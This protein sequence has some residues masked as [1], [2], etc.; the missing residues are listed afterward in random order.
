MSGNPL[1]S[2]G[3]AT[4]EY[5]A[6][7][8]L[9]VKTT[10]DGVELFVRF[11]GARRLVCEVTPADVNR[12]LA[13]MT[14]HLAVRRKRLAALRAF[15]KWAVANGSAGSDPTAGII[16]RARPQPRSLDEAPGTAPLRALGGAVPTVAWAARR[17]V[18]GRAQRDEIATETVASFRQI[19]GLF[20]D[21]VGWQ[22]QLSA[23]SKGDVLAWLEEMECSPTTRRHRLSAVRNFFAWALEEELIERNPTAGIKP[24]KSPRTVPRNLTT[25]QVQR[26]LDACADARERVIVLL[27][28]CQGLRSKEVATLELG[29][30][31]FDNRVLVVRNGKGGHQRILPLA[32]EAAWAIERYLAEQE[33]VV[34]GPLIL[35]E[36]NVPSEGIRPRRVV[37]IVSEVMRRANV[38]DAGHS[39]RHT[40]AADLLAQGANLRDVQ[41]ALGHATIATTQ[42]YLPFTATNQLRPLVGAKRYLGRLGPSPAAPAEAAE[43]G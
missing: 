41:T 21:Y 39:L 33:R 36:G 27:M 29:D 35:S 31:D 43:V 5:R 1:A 12:W 11:I 9:A 37:R 32:E 14:E 20:A 10:G 30:L 26:V 6:Q 13:E 17:Y 22:T 24:A 2:L 18:Y 19:L 8:A 15:F 42:V 28:V 25:E 4:S 40:F 34:A 23:I 7:N 38:N 3:D 16:V